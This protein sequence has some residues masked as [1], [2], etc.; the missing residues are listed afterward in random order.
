MQNTFPGRGTRGTRRIQDLY[1]ARYRTNIVWTGSSSPSGPS[2]RL[3]WH[4]GS[5]STNKWRRIGGCTGT[6]VEATVRPLATGRPQDRDGWWDRGYDFAG[7]AEA[8]MVRALEINEHSANQNAPFLRS[9][10]TARRGPNGRQR[11]GRGFGRD[12]LLE[13]WTVGMRVAVL[14]VAWIGTATGGEEEAAQII[15]GFGWSDST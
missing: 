9:Q 6:T 2:S 1:C 3:S 10:T 5:T 4:G 11:M 7:L 15:E 14:A 13:D 12:T 8:S